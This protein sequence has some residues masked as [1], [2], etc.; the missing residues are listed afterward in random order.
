MWAENS[1][2]CFLKKK[3]WL[4]QIESHNESGGGDAEKHLADDGR[5][6]VG[7]PVLHGGAPPARNRS[8]G[9]GATVEGGGKGLLHSRSGE[10]TGLGSGGAGAAQDAPSQSDGDGGSVEG[11]G[12][13]REDGGKS[14]HTRGGGATGKGALRVDGGEDADAEE[15]GGGLGEGGE[16]L[17]R[18]D[19]S[20]T[21]VDIGVIDDEGRISEDLKVKKKGA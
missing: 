7:D 2:I 4:F 3:A 12:D 20:G 17:P 10:N 18:V 13:G 5:N 21:E 11:G 8:D 6:G 15:S 9:D 16:G 1:E 14:N 19:G